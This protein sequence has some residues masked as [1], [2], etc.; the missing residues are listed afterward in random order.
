VIQENCHSQDATLARAR[1][2]YARG[3]VFMF[4]FVFFS[5]ACF[6]HPSSPAG[7]ESP[8]SATLQG[9]LGLNTVPSARMSQAGTVTAG[10]STLDPYA[11]AY[12]GFQ[13][14]PPLSINLRQSAEVSNI[15]DSADRLYPGVD[16][17]LRLLDES[18]RRPALV[19]GL[20]AAAG[21]KRMAG[22]Y[23]T[24]SKRY[25]D[26]DFTAG[27]GWGRFGQAGHMDNPLG[28]IFSHF[29]TSR[30][31]DGEMPNEPSDWFT[32]SQIGF[33]GGVEYFMPFPDNVS[34]KLDWEAERY[35]AEKAAFGF[36][37]PPPWGASLNYRPVPWADINVGVQGGEKIMGRFSLKGSPESWP[38]G[39]HNDT[40]PPLFPQRRAGIADV[41]AMKRGD[42]NGNLSIYDV[43]HDA[44][45]IRAKLNLNPHIP[46]PQQIGRAARV[47]ARPGGTAA[48]EFVITPRMFNLRGPSIRL[49]RADF[50]RALAQLQGSP[51]EIWRNADF[52]K[53]GKGS[54]NAGGLRLPH[55]REDLRGSGR[56]QAERGIRPRRP[57]L[58][59]SG[60]RR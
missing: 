8:Y 26:F 34:V 55:R 48:E 53:A 56:E 22:E 23:L 45:Q 52:G 33:F 15:H 3:A 6:F 31:M 5:G 35:G 40:P 11:H 29:R 24:L 19:L 12:I 42:E 47:M 49:L 39:T 58:L 36:D 44:R 60:R 51:V 41:A 20:Q 1:R 54:E 9:P 14:A 46:A 2:D 37:A 25:N 7:A 13:V 57:S 16:I 21:H 28:H 17:R 43:T 38:F 27:M 32:G 4:W 30:S 10:I 18:A 59:E 50:E